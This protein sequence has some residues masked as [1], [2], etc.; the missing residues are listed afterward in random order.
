[1]GAPP[2]EPGRWLDC[3][4]MMCPLPIIELGR[5]ARGCAP[6]ALLG[7]EGDD[8]ALPD[9]LRAWCRAHRH[10]LLWLEREGRRSRSVVRLASP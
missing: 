2:I 10:E 1:M 5:A 6:G 3:T 4:G 8:P 7:L 9:D